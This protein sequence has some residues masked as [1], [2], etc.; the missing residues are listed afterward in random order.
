METP[1]PSSVGSSKPRWS[2]RDSPGAQVAVVRDSKVIYETA[3]GL[4]ARDGNDPVTLTTRFAIGS[5][6]KQFTA[7]AIM[8][9]VEEDG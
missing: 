7:T 2:N 6:G 9:L 8:M 3:L 5:M 1:V 4:T